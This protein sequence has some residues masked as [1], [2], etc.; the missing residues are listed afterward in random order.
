MDSPKVSNAIPAQPT[1]P[2]PGENPAYTVD[3]LRDE[4][5][6]GAF[7]LLNQA[8]ANFTPFLADICNPE[9]NLAAEIEHWISE[10]QELDRR[11]QR[12]ALRK[13][14]EATK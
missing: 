10:L 5:L 2:P 1:A 14:S 3:Q 12:L 8:A 11:R 7:E 4:I 6:A 9:S 13:I